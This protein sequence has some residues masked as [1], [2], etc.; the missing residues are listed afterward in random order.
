MRGRS[1]IFNE[2]E[3]L[4]KARNIFW[5]KGYDASSTDELLEDMG[6][7]KGS[8]YHTF[9]GGKKELFTKV[10]QQFSDE[11]IAQFKRDIASSKNP[12]D[13]VKQ[14]FLG[15]ASANNKTH[16]LGCF[17][18]NTVAELASIDSALSIFASNLLKRLET[19]FAEVIATAQQ[20][21]DLKTREDAVVLAAYLL[22]VWTG[23]SITRRIYPDEK[24]LRPL[25]EL[26]LR[27]IQ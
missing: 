21:G 19:L 25:I 2:D 6:I 7:G 9:K 24:T 12:V 20:K 3:V 4:L 5:S 27:V 23:L 16:L 1:K 15:I 10:L 8:F 11:A 13:E 22:T 18:C 14:F 26:Q 17:L